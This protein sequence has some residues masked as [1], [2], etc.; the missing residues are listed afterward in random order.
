MEIVVILVLVGLV[1]AYTKRRNRR[2][3][4]PPELG[5]VGWVAGTNWHVV[6]PLAR[7]EVRRFVAHPAFL[8]GLVTAP[9]ILMMAG[10]VDPGSVS[11][12]REV[13]TGIALGLVPFGWLVIIAT[14]LMTTRPARTGTDALFST[15]PAPQSVRTGGLLGTAPAAFVAAGVLAVGWVVLLQGGN[16]V[17]VGSPEWAEIAAGLFI[18][19]GSVTVG[20]AVAR[21][22]PHPIFGV[23][24]AFT[25]AFIQARFFEIGSWPWNLSEGS[26]YRF[27]GFLADP[28]GSDPS[29]E[30]RP[31]GWHLVYLA[32]LVVIMG[33]VALA[34]RTGMPRA[35][36]GTLAVAV[37][38]TAFVGWVQTR[39]A[40]DGQV[41]TM[42]SHL[43]EPS[44][45]HA[46][47]QHGTVRYCTFAASRSFVPR[48]RTSVESV[49]GLVPAAV[50]A[51]PL[52]VA[53]R[54]PTVIGNSNCSPVPYTHTLV[55]EV[56]QRLNPERVWPADG[57][58]HPGI[59]AFACGGDQV[60]GLFLGVQ[61]GSWAV[62]LPPA[63]HG[64]DTRCVADRQAR[65]VVALWLGAAAS[66]DGEHNFR[67]M[68]AEERSSHLVF[69]DWNDPP[70]WG[71]KFATADVTMAVAMLALP[72]DEVTRILEQHWATIVDPNTTAATLAS[73]LGID[74]AASVVSSE[75]RC[76]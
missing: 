48:W 35:L 21:L 34:I 49:L 42:I 72:T 18:A 29:L 50:A 8:A 13:S 6:P 46:C 15:L 70:M 1:V 67:Q 58:I 7:A 47:E 74:T 68:Y 37:G 10:S 40:T 5:P 39:P 14:H 43:Y 33:C 76:A 25:C 57:A 20:V 32:G 63:P 53:D 27:L 4:A 55:P 38:A 24:A 66:P 69:T 17:I 19:A 64:R 60:H 3:D 65:S 9:L 23:A 59:D 51:R 44:S 36:A 45:R 61:T 12:W 26:P 2:E 75:S 31:A 54:V 52:E 11:T 30:I 22:L 71:V 16:R 62:G 28:T 41:A 73:L 56:A